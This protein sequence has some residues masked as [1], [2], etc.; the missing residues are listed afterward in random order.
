MSQVK[1][2][3]GESQGTEQIKS[4]PGGFTAESNPEFGCFS[5]DKVMSQMKLKDMANDD[6]ADMQRRPFESVPN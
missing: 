5:N 4:V 6:A 3:K 2:Y 1:T